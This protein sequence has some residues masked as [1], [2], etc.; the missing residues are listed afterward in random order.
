V[1]IEDGLIQVICEACVELKVDGM[2]PDIVIAKTA[3]TMAAFENKAEVS[4][5]H[6]L[7]AAELALSHRTRENGFLEPATSQEIRDS[8]A[9]KLQE[10]RQ[11]ESES[12]R[13]AEDAKS[14]RSGN[15][16]E[17]KERKR[18]LLPPFGFRRFTNLRKNWPRPR[19]LILTIF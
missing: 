7:K 14:K 19:S 16:C 3:R 18:K 9:R 13:I 6:V 11:T 4:P 12:N 10:S 1:R 2:R 17:A 5:E 8:F 15:Q